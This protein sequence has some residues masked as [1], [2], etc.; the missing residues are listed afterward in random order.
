MEPANVML[1][2][3][4][5]TVLPSVILLPHAVVKVLAMPMEPVFA[6]PTSLEPTAAN[7]L[8]YIT[9]DV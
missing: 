2:I 3:L 4:D 7:V 9:K 8:P 6:T 1:A 5:L